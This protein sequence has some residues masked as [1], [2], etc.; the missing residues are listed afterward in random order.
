MHPTAEASQSATLKMSSPFR[1]VRRS[2]I[3]ATLAVGDFISYGA[4]KCL[5]LLNEVHPSAFN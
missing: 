2:D 5:T 4:L 1:H 3:T